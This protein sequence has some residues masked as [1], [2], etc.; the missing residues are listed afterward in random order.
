MLQN[1]C[2]VSGVTNQKPYIIYALR[3]HAFLLSL[4]LAPQM[5]REAS[6]CVGFYAIKFAVHGAAV[7]ETSSNFQVGHPGCV[8]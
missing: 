7:K 3:G 6:V 2:C 5:S 1:P 4:S 8:V